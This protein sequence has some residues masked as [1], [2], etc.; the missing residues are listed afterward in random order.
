MYG[1][2]WV[3]CM[4]TIAADDAS[5]ATVAVVDGDNW[6]IVGNDSDNAVSLNVRLLARHRKAQGYVNY[7]KTSTKTRHGGTESDPKAAVYVSVRME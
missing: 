2:D 6:G 4:S 5:V 1:D 7:T 3:I